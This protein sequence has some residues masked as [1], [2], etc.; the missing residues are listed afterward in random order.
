MNKPYV[1]AAPEQFEESV[2]IGTDIIPVVL[3]PS[4]AAPEFQRLY[5]RLVNDQIKCH[6]TNLTPDDMQALNQEIGGCIT[7]MMQLIFG[8]DGSDKVICY[9]R[10][11]YTQ[12]IFAIIPFIRD[13]IKPMLDHYV[14]E[15]G[16]SYRKAARRRFGR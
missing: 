15:L 14:A 16:K 7:T 3:D 4:T 11:N 10:S 12:L 9:Y 2:Q 8:V 13:R 6:D 1:L 5:N